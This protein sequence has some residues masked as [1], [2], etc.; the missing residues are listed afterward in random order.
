MCYVPLGLQPCHLTSSA[1]RHCV[2][3]CVFCVH[4]RTYTAPPAMQSSVRILQCKFYSESTGFI[5][6]DFHAVTDGCLPAAS[7][8][9]FT[10]IS[11]FV[12][13]IGDCM[14][15][16]HQPLLHIIFKQ[17]KYAFVPLCLRVC[18]AS[19]IFTVEFSQC[20]LACGL[21]SIGCLWGISAKVD[22]AS[23]DWCGLN[24]AAQSRVFMFF[25]VYLLEAALFSLNTESCTEH[26][27]PIRIV[28]NK[29]WLTFKILA[30]WLMLLSRVT[31]GV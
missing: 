30:I 13:P 18:Y 22:S 8:F 25:C 26:C 5:T 27:H 17:F 4:M 21:V 11:I 3:V 6:R 15:V 20:S 23:I 28:V 29:L 31:Y 24:P 7:L 1:S 12:R 16:A 14:D 2:C 10:S 19:Y 9:Q